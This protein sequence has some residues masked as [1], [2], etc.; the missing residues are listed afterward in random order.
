MRKI[1]KSL[2]SYQLESYKRC[3]AVSTYIFIYLHVSTYLY[4][5]SHISHHG[6]RIRSESELQFFWFLL[7]ESDRESEIPKKIGTAIPFLDWFQ[8]DSDALVLE[9]QIRLIS[10][11]ETIMKF[12]TGAMAAGGVRQPAVIQGGNLP[13]HD[14][15]LNI[16][17]FMISK[18]DGAIDDRVTYELWCILWIMLCRFQI[19]PDYWLLCTF[20]Q[21]QS[22]AVAGFFLVTDCSTV[23]LMT[24]TWR[25]WSGCW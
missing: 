17:W 1:P 12:H 5:S 10:N 14:C 16:H 11:S 15:V 8:S 2:K 4:I 23:L 22:P 24:L 20:G 6:F 25:F 19:V 3:F 7:L 9:H 21:P 18:G 13:W